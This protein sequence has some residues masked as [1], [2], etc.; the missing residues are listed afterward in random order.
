MQCFSEITIACPS[1]EEKVEE[2]EYLSLTK[3]LADVTM[4]R[5]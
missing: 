1:Q 2:I 5:T 4:E 3:D